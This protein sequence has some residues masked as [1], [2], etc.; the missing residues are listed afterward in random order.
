[1][2][3]KFLKYD[4]SSEK[5]Y[6]KLSYLRVVVVNKEHHLKHKFKLN[7]WLFLYNLI[8][9]IWECISFLFWILERLKIRL[10]SQNKTW[11]EFYWLFNYFKVAYRSV[12]LSSESY[13]NFC[14]QETQLLIF[15]SRSF[16]R[17]QFIIISYQVLDFFKCFS[18]ITFYLIILSEFS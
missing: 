12:R 10:K 4:H 8:T 6:M 9:K 11:F 7:G 17:I 18:V 16:Y 15:I 1:M 5:N 13:S 2:K 14:T 3:K